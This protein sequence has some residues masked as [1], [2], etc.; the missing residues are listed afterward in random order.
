MAS[1]FFALIWCVMDL[2]QRK[3][4]INAKSKIFS[5]A[6]ESPLKGASAKGY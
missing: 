4:P 2:D 3:F 5:K 1:F 6:L